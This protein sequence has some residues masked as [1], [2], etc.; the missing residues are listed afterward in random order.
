MRTMPPMVTFNNRRFS[1]DQIFSLYP[2]SRGVA[3]VGMALYLC[4]FPGIMALSEAITLQ[5]PIAAD[6]RRSRGQ[7]APGERLIEGL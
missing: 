3:G 1:A 6:S 2:P 4:L 5:S 7:R